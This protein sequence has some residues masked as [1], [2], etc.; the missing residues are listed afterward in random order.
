MTKLCF[1]PKTTKYGNSSSDSTKIEIVKKS[2]DR[3]LLKWSKQAFNYYP[4]KI[5]CQD[6]EFIPIFTPCKCYTPLF[7]CKA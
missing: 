5:I 6:S 4:M 7:K 3:V 1:G 2:C